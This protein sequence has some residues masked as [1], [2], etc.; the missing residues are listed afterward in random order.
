MLVDSQT[1]GKCG[2][3]GPSG[4]RGQPVQRAGPSLSEMAKDFAQLHHGKVE[5]QCLLKK[6][7][8]LL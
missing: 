5:A 1:D 6:P 3:G 4:A 8:D 2:V 7:Q